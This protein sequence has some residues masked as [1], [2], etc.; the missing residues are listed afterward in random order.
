MPFREITW[1]L[2]GPGKALMFTRV[3]VNGGEIEDPHHF[4]NSAE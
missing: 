4:K 3:D 2:Q 1:W